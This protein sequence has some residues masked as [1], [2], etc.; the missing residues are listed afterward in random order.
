MR[1]GI[2]TGGGDAPGLNGI[3]EAAGKTIL[4][5]GHELVGI[6]DG[7]EGVFDDRTKIL[8][9]ESL[10]G[11]HQVAGTCLGTSN[12]C[13]TEGRESE[14]LEKYKK[15]N[16]DGIIVAGGDGTFRGLSEF[17]EEIKVIGVP[18]TI[19]NDLSGTEVT[20]G[21]DT[22]CH[23][24]ADAV[25]ALRATAH[26][27]RRVIVVE[28]M[29]RTAGWIALG[30]GLA[31]YADAILIPERPFE[32]KK[33]LQ[34]INEKKKTQ[35]GFLM[36]VAEG[37][38]AVGE[39]AEVAFKVEGAPQEERLGG[40]S[41]RMAKWIEL[42]TGWDGRHVILGHLQRSH[43]PTTTDRF[44]T[45]AM[46]VTVGKMVKENAW[47][48]AAVF[49]KGKVTQVPIT[50]LM[51]EPRLVEKDHRWVNMAQSLGIFI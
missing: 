36:V 12:K 37:A 1:I 18:K 35:R 13:G 26:A 41:Q 14:F 32:R 38:H 17:K 22:A 34:Y 50:E 51:G 30:G 39:S 48:Q 40:I 31:S 43:S 9:A 5:M 46:G 24:V 45:L 16:L 44:L 49:K 3:I 42:E 2:L 7:F 6:E 8:T 25:D 23:V 19:D 27:H 29:G 28:T 47:G 20:F 11:L 33:L 4:N 10:K 21:Y 15:L